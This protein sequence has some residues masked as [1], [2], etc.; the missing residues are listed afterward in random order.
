MPSWYQGTTLGD[1]DLTTLSGHT[2]QPCGDP[3][4]PTRPGRVLWICLVLIG[5]EAREEHTDPPV[6]CPYAQPVMSRASSSQP[7]G[8]RCGHYLHLPPL[9]PGLWCPLGELHAHL[10]RGPSFSESNPVPPA[11]LLGLWVC[12]SPAWTIISQRTRA[13]WLGAALW[14]SQT[15]I[16]VVF[17]SSV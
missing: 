16:F 8:Y 13:N 9:C 6:S 17:P 14:L 3:S 7:C 1:W 5:V 11:H 10:P 4:C 15:H 12:T 2:P